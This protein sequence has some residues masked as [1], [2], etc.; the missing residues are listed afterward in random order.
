M[1]VYLLTNFCLLAPLKS[2]ARH[3]SSALLRS[4]ILML[5][6][7]EIFHVNFLRDSAI[8]NLKS[9]HVREYHRKFQIE[10]ETI[11]GYLSLA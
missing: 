8:C 6:S 4:E 10:F 9:I 3:Q 7:E 1:I 5:Q 11:L 2:L